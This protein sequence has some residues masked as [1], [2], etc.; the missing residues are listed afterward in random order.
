MV[1]SPPSIITANPNLYTTVPHCTTN[2]LPVLSFDLPLDV[3]LS[4]HLA[5]YIFAFRSS[6]DA[7]KC[8]TILHTRLIFQPLFSQCQLSAFILFRTTADSAFRFFRDAQPNFIP[9]FTMLYHAVGAFRLSLFLVV[10]FFIPVFIR[11]YFLEIEMYK[12]LSN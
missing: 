1:N 11:S 10:V 5:S 4:L 8:C 9:L 7:I 12:F 6:V 3:C 2:F